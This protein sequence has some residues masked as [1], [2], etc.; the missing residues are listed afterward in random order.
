MAIVRSATI[1]S[2]NGKKV[3]LD[4]KPTLEEAQRIVGGYVE[5][6]HGRDQHGAFQ[7]LVNEDG[8]PLRLPFNQAATECYKVSEIAGDVILLR[9]W[10]FS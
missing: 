10:R 2:A 9:G 8:W 3:E 4:H 5:V 6:A 1:I 7:L